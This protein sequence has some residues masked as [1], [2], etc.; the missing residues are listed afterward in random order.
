VASDALLIPNAALRRRGAQT[1]VWM[2]SEGRLRFVPVRAGDQGLDGKVH[3]IDGL[4][5]GDEVVL[6]S[7]RDLEEGSRIEVVSALGGKAP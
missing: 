3:I 2:R 1:G 7:E 6:Y 5:A 4:K